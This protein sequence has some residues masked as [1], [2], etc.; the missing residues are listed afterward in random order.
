MTKVYYRD[1][2]AKAEFEENLKAKALRFDQELTELM[3]KARLYNDQ[4]QR[5]YKSFTVDNSASLEFYSALSDAMYLVRELNAQMENQRHHLRR[6]QEK[7]DLE[8]VQNG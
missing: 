8:Q 7:I 3:H 5:F 1:L 6:L 2:Q 4:I